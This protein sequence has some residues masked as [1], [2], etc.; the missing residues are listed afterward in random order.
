L[1]YKKACICFSGLE[2]RKHWALG[3][4]WTKVALWFR[5]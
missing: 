2:G 3:G 1:F 5:V 4:G